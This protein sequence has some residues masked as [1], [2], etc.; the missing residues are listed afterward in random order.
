MSKVLM[1]FIDASNEKSEASMYVDSAITDL[2]ITAI[3][4]AVDGLTLGNRQK[5]VFTQTTD[6][7][8]G[9]LGKSSNNFAQRET[10]FLVKSIDQV[11]G[12]QVQHELPTADLAELGSDGATVPLDAGAGL[13]LKTAF[14]ANVLSIDGNA[15]SVYEI[16]HVGRNL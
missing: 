10:K 8:A 3:T 16:E 14:D 9:T 11:N 4:D 15:I 12:K 7:D 5:T 13:A 2:N 1:P 6:K